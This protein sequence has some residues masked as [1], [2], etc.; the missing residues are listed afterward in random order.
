MSADFRILCFRHIC[1]GISTASH[2]TINLAATC[3]WAARPV[4]YDTLIKYWCEVRFSAVAF[5]PVSE[6]FSGPH[7]SNTSQPLSISPLPFPSADF[8]PPSVLPPSPPQFRVSMGSVHHLYSGESHAPRSAIKKKYQIQSSP[9]FTRSPA[10]A[11][12]LSPPRRLNEG[13]RSPSRGPLTMPTAVVTDTTTAFVAD[14]RARFE[15]GSFRRH[16]ERPSRSKV[17]LPHSQ[18]AKKTHRQ[19]AIHVKA[20]LKKFVRDERRQLF[21]SAAEKTRRRPARSRLLRALGFYTWKCIDFAPFE[22]PPRSGGPI[23]LTRNDR[24]CVDVTSRS[25]RGGPLAAARPPP[26]S[27]DVATMRTRSFRVN[28]IDP[29]F[30]NARKR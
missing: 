12:I 19:E 1:K 7:P 6:N 24:V 13:R 15:S 18:T 23:A 30:T 27:F 25:R 10:G 21:T 26:T 14:S 22:T 3:E 20:T 16:P 17:W 28:T 2:G 11:E 9:K 5:R 4:Q 29:L 8:F